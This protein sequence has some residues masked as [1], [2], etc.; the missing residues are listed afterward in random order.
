VAFLHFFAFSARS[1]SAARSIFCSIWP[2]LA[3]SGRLLHQPAA[4]R[5]HQEAGVGGLVVV[6]R[7]NGTNTAAAP[8]AAISVTV[9]AP[10]RQT[11]MSASAK[12][13][14]VSSMKGVSSACT[15]AAW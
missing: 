5:I 7:R 14:A 1:N 9:L 8:T 10:A 6:H 3:A 4:A 13:L 12:A 2:G 15:P 11:M